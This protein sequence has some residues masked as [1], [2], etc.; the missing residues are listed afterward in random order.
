MKLESAE[1]MNP[2][3]MKPKRPILRL[4]KIKIA[5]YKDKGKI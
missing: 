1:K 4:I 2:K 3:K 5:K